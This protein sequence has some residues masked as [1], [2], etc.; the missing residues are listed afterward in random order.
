MANSV[1]LLG[2]GASMDAGVPGAYQLTEDVYNFLAKT[3]HSRNAVLFGFVISKLITQKARLGESPFSKL[4]IEEV[5]DALR[6]FLIREGDPISEFVTSWDAGIAEEK[7]N[8]AHFESALKNLVS[9]SIRAASH[10]ISIPFEDRLYQNVSK[11][12]SI[13]LEKTN[14]PNTNDAKLYP[15]TAA[16][17]ECLQPSETNTDYMCALVN[18]AAKECDIIGSLNYDLLLEKACDDEKLSFSYGLSSWN[19]RKTI[20]YDRA[21]LRIAK[22]HGSLNWVEKQDDIEVS[23]EPFRGKRALIFGGDHSKLV[24][25]GPYLQLRYTF[26]KRLRSTTRLGIIGYSFQDAHINAMLRLWV[27]TKRRAKLV[28]VNPAL[29][30]NSLNELGRWFDTDTNGIA[31]HRIEIVH[32]RKP[33]REAM[34]QFI[35]EMSAQPVLPSA[36][37]DNLGVRIEG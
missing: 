9:Q 12:I 16:L 14:S 19:D 10:D 26:E 18:Y 28:I 34:N 36:D 22:L 13:G 8:G 29:P 6:R 35:R 15:Y 7:F 21:D 1:I 24:P 32:I 3:P 31:R 27:A 23:S 2:A 33:A 25:H 5:Y 11:A 20:R 37:R 4:N 30:A 17:A